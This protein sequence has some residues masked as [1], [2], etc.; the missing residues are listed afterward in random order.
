MTE[1]REVRRT[2][3]SQHWLPEAGMRT[4]CLHSPTAGAP[5]FC[6]CRLRFPVGNWGVTCSVEEWLQALD[7]AYKQAQQ[8]EE[9]DRER[10]VRGLATDVHCGFGWARWRVGETVHAG[11]GFPV[12]HVRGAADRHPPSRIPAG[13]QHEAHPG[14]AGAQGAG[15]GGEAGS[16]ARLCSAK[17][18]SSPR[19]LWWCG[20]RV[21]C[22]E[23]HVAA[24][25]GWQL[26]RI[27]LSTAA[28]ADHAAPNLDVTP[29]LL[30]PDR[31]RQACWSAMWTAPTWLRALSSCTTPCGASQVGVG[32]TGRLLQVCHAQHGQRPLL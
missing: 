18:Q 8:A 11:G 14:R 21:A 26:L 23:K 9:E 3:A 4:C 29:P 15:G 28:A 13:W 20:G 31:R 5:C 7:A 17:G 2:V 12:S 22:Q 1:A 30:A 6:C 24:C 19:W 16:G 27:H 32:A 10:Q 25:V